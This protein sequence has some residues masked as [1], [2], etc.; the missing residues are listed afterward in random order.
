MRVWSST[1]CFQPMDRHLFSDAIPKQMTTFLRALRYMNVHYVC[2]I[3][4]KNQG[5]NI[6]E[7]YLLFI[8]CYLQFRDEMIR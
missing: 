7:Q 3:Q 4:S 2:M 8:A 1:F 5:N 6:R